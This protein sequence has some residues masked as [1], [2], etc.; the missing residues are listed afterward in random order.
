MK[1]RAMQA[2]YKMALDPIAET[3]A[4]PNSYGFRPERCTADAMQQCYILLAKTSMSAEW[5]LEGDIKG[6]FDNISHDWMITNIPMD[7][8]ILK[9][10]LKAGF[11]EKGELI[12]T[13]AG[14]PQGGIIS[15]VLAN[16]VLNGLESLLLKHWPDRTTKKHKGYVI[17]N[18]KKRRIYDFFPRPKVQLV[19]YADDFII[20]G[21]SKEQLENE[22][23]PVVEAFL[24]E[25]GLVLSQEKTRVTHISEGFDFLG[26]NYRRYSNG[27][28]LITPSKKNV[29]AFLQKVRGIIL[30]N[31]AAKQ[32][33]LI[34][35]LN[36]IIR[37]WAEYHRWIVAAAVFQKVDH[38]IFKAL[39]SW[40][41]RRHHKRG[42][43]WIKR[44]YFSASSKRKWWFGT[45]VMEEG[46]KRMVTL[47]AADSIKVRKRWTKVQAKAN[48]YDPD[49]RN[50]FKDRTKSKMESS[51]SHR[52][53]VRSL[54]LEQN[55]ICPTCRR[56]IT[57]ITGWHNHHIIRKMDGG[58]DENANRVLLHENCHRQTHSRK[59]EVRKPVPRQVELI[60]A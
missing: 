59:V 16:M 49:Y 7:K 22:I 27:K 56:M 18:G 25:R 36:P 57:E 46:M 55:G 26:W 51:V 53:A 8:V 48:P 20:T 40:A 54:W 34:K 29:K 13:D 35:V 19:R 6:C 1:D 28:F 52:K 32:E 9:K 50:Y 3:T 42:E 17:E 21:S 5:V 44:K 12:P 60:E 45:Q 10:W 31:K 15:P 30:K 11:I 39:W 58:S 23:K 38:H 2:L 4:D 14:T 47:F 43:R 24:A 37:G 41:R 33:Q